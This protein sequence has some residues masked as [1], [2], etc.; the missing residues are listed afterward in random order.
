M[1]VVDKIAEVPVED[2]GAGEISKPVSPV[3]INQAEV[4]E[5]N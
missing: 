1:D 3:T 4:I 2:N 5:E